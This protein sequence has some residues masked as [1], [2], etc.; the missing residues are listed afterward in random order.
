MRGSR[1][2][3][4]VAPSVAAFAFIAQNF[5][6]AFAQTPQ[7]SPSPQ[8]APPEAT[9]EEEIVVTGQRMPGSV[10]GDARPEIT[11]NPG[12]IRAYAT[13]SVGEL[14]AALAPQT[15]SS[16]LRGAGAP[17]VLVNGRR[18]ASPQEVRDLPTEAIMRVE[19]FNEQ[20][21]LQYG[22]SPDQRVV[23]LILRPRYTVNTADLALSRARGDAQASWDVDA[24][25]VEFNRADRT[26]LVFGAEAASAI[27][28]L[29]ADIRAPVSGLDARSA[30]T[31]APETQTQFVSGVLSRG[32]QD[33]LTATGTLRVEQSET[34]SLLGLDPLSG[35]RQER[36]TRN[37][38]VRASAS[39]DGSGDGWQ[40]TSSGSV[41]LTNR[42]IATKGA[43]QRASK[44]NE[45]T[46]ELAFNANG[47][48]ID[49][50]AGV[51][52]ANGRFWIEQRDFDSASQTLAGLTATELSRSAFGARVGATAPLLKR[53]EGFG[54]AFGDVS[55]NA[56]VSLESLSDF[57]TLETAS[58]GLSW[59]PL[60]GLR[61]SAQA[62]VSDSAPSLQQRGDP[63]LATPNASVFDVARGE[64]ASVT[65]VTGGAPTLRAED[66]QDVQVSMN[67]SPE[68]IR[69]LTIQASFAN[70]S[71]DN[72][73]NALPTNLAQTETAFAS[74]YIRDGLGRLIG[75]DV[76]PVNLANRDTQTVRWGFSFSQGF[77]EPIPPPLGSA[78]WGPG[79]APWGSGPPP[80]GDG[81]PPWMRE[82]QSSATPGASG[83]AAGPR[84]DARQRGGGQPGR[85]S[86]S[87]FH[88]MRLEDTVRLA[89]G[90][91][92]IDL[93]KLG[94]LAGDGESRHTV[95]LDTGLSFRGI[96]VRLNGAWE[97][98]RTLKTG[99]GDLD[100][101]D[102]LTLNARAF[103]AFDQQQD[104]LRDAP[105]LRGAR[106]SLSIQNLTNSA[107][108]V[109]DGTNLTPYAY[110]DGF[111]AP[112]GR[113][114]QV[115]LRK[116]F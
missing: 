55:V 83:A 81:P 11:L 62:S 17:I 16:S 3:V 43:T 89:P 97:S 46:T 75:L 15:G 42:D 39:L 114:V 66:R 1:F 100:V 107:P 104:L 102:R 110:Q 14:L 30:R 69:G 99:A 106:A 21:A 88:T 98:G 36:D 18:T 33:Q 57:D 52:R 40:W 109:R 103:I 25:R 77:G 24:S 32:L 56:A 44:R 115:S 7:P 53:E 87:V 85:F 105:W 28:E 93:L 31:V 108:D 5:A 22:F 26:T 13:S 59:S 23:N 10:P 72:G 112:Q 78:P 61:F 54:A 67:W 49:A 20:L 71:T 47:P 65:R 8:Q 41:N 111:L 76:R 29:E 35:A 74:R 27:T 82:G 38:A 34:L 12:E 37:S 50:P 80:W 95:Q 60:P 9:N 63:I 101:S 2:S 91:G 64:T 58:A 92:D 116:Q 19:I 6:P 79:L 113:V 96:G 48:W 84:G 90:T 70:N 45:L 86:L 94:G 51:V 68:A 73:I 4:F